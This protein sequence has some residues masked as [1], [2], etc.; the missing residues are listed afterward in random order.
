MSKPVFI[1]GLLLR[2]ETRRGGQFKKG[3]HVFYHTLDLCGGKGAVHPIREH[4]S[5][6][7]PK[8]SSSVLSHA[9][10]GGVARRFTCNRNKSGLA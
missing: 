7:E 4:Y 6:F 1:K 5:F 3:F 9:F 2:F 10:T 8:G